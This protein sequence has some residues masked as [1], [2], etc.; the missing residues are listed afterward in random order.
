MAELK[1]EKLS[2]RK[3]EW[4]EILASKEFKEISIGETLCFNTENLIGRTLYV[5]LASLTNDARMQNVNVRLVVNEVKNKKACTKLEGYE[6]LPAFIRRVVKLGKDRA[7]DSFIYKTKDNI[8]VVMK[9][10]LITK[11]KVKHSVLSNLRL[12]ARDFLEKYVVKID[13]DELVFD[14][15][16]YKLQKELKSNLK[17]VYPLDVAEIRIMELV[18]KSS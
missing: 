15:I 3:K 10:L 18:K 1:Q 6:V 17:R 14:L 11:N 5:N 9:P 4:F 7:D 13:Y 12:T 8:D 16:N 2:K